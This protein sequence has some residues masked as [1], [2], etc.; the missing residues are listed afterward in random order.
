MTIGVRAASAAAEWSSAVTVVWTLS[1]SRCRT[2]HT[3]HEHLNSVA[4][5][6][7]RPGPE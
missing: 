2:A 7:K 3:P 6:T 1:A 5:R 4:I